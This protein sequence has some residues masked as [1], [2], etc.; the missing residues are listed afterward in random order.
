MISE[1]LALGGLIKRNR[2]LSRVQQLINQGSET[3][4][5]TNAGIIA[6]GA[7]VWVD[8]AAEFPESRTFFPLD[9]IE[10]INNSAQ[11]IT[12]YLNSHTVSETVPS[13][14]IKPINGKAIRQF[15][16]KNNGAAGIAA[17][18]IIVHLKRLPPDVQ[19]VVTGGMRG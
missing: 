12:L 5:Y 4:E 14:M 10:V 11:E 13:Y 9:S 7:V 2:P 6:A 19:V 16:L 18:E 3:Y 8:V 17:G 15:G 1:I